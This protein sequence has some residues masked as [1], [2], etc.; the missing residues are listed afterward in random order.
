ML[1]QKGPEKQNILHVGV[2]R[3]YQFPPTATG[4]INSEGTPVCGTHPLEIAAILEGLSKDHQM[5][6]L[7]IDAE[8]LALIKNAETFPVEQE[9]RFR[10]RSLQ[11]YLRNTR[12]TH[13]DYNLINIPETFKRKRASG[14]IRFLEGDVVISDLSSYGPFDFIQCLNVFF[15]LPFQ[16]RGSSND[17][18][19]RE[20]LTLALYNLIRNLHQNGVLLAEERNNDST[21]LNIPTKHILD[22]IFCKRGLVKIERVVE[23]SSKT[24][25][26]FIRKI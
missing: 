13:A 20:I 18:A 11:R 22:E 21:G 19:G 3:R 4:G 24:R 26:I 6:I 8:N 23:E 25:D 10:N 17:G 2:G 12:Q 7:D 1:L 5:T 15:H 16:Y 9:A 14:E